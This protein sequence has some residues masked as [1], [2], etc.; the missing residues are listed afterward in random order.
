MENWK[1]CSPP[2]SIKYAC[3]TSFPRTAA[4]NHWIWRYNVTSFLCCPISVVKSM[5]QPSIPPG[6][7][8]QPVGFMSDPD[9]FCPTLKNVR[10][11]S[12]IDVHR[13]LKSLL[14]IV[15]VSVYQILC[16]CSKQNISMA[17][18]KI[19]W[20]FSQPKCQVCFSYPIRGFP[21][22]MTFVHSR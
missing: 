3:P 19:C 22:N 17:A 18:T 14:V 13:I 11:W 5:W 16:I 4:R 15:L 12:R 9:Y 10:N 7:L 2:S 21:H 1:S 8:N 20:N 6:T